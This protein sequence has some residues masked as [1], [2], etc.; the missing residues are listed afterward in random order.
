MCA[1][2]CV[3]HLATETHHVA[4]LHLPLLPSVRLPISMVSALAACQNP[5]WTGPPPRYGESMHIT[6]LLCIYDLSRSGMIPCCMEALFQS[7]RPLNP[8]CIISL[9]SARREKPQGTSAIRERSVSASK[10]R[11]ARAR[12]AV[13]PTHM[14]I[15]RMAIHSLPASLG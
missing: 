10:P 11:F 9:L 1:C 2:V 7:P 15:T 3:F 8:L 6:S 5:L 14:A 12:A 4:S 13:L